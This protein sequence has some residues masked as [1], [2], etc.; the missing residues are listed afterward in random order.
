[1]KSRIAGLIICGAVIVGFALLRANSTNEKHASLMSSTNVNP[2]SNQPAK[3]PDD[4]QM[5]FMQLLVKAQETNKSLPKM[6]DEVV[7]F[8]SVVPRRERGIT[9]MYTLVGI[10]SADFD[11]AEFKGLIRGE[12]VNAYATN[13]EMRPYRDAGIT[14]TYTY[15]FEDGTTAASVDILPTDT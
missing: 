12:L 1:M 9:Y 7:R 10:D 13:P 4:E 14:L 3:L 15:R 11:G 6:L 2:R 5:L 8:D